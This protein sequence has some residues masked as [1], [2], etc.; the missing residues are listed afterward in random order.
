M[1]KKKEERGRK[2][3]MGTKRVI[4]MQNR[5]ELQQTMHNRS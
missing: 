1:Y 4:K 3:E 5:D 2:R